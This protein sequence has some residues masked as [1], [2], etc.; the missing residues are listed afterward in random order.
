MKEDWYNCILE[1]QYGRTD[2]K[3]LQ[4]GDKFY[5]EDGNELKLVISSKRVRRVIDERP[6]YDFMDEYCKSGNNGLLVFAVLIA[7]AALIGWLY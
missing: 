7:I 2:I 4:I 3:A 5:D 1:D 6:E